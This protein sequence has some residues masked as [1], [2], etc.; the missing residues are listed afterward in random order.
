MINEGVA[1]L[2]IG[3]AII[4]AAIAAMPRCPECG[5]FRSVPDSCDPVLRHCR[6][7][8]TVFQPGGRR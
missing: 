5:C 2:A 8:L 1:L 6:R 3:A 7:C 4:A